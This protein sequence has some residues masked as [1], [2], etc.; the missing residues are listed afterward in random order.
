[1]SL[2]KP[3]LA[4]RKRRERERRIVMLCR[5]LDKRVAYAEK[6]KRGGT[7]RAFL[8]LAEQTRQELREIDH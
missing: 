5:R 6:Y 7:R 4:A 2:S 3:Q 1:M 8:I